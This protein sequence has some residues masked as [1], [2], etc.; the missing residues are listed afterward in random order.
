MEVI[1]H[2]KPKLGKVKMTC[3]DP[4][5][6]KLEQ[7][8]EAVKA[9]FSKPNFTMLCG[10]MGSG[11][12]STTIKCL[13][14]FLKKTHSDMIVVIP[15]VSLAS[16]NPADNVFSKWTPEGNLYHE[17]NEDTLKEIYE[18]VLANAE[19][20]NYTIVIIDDFGHLLK[21]KKIETMLQKFVIKIR[22]LKIGQLWL[23]TQNYF[24]T[25]KKLRELATNVF[26]WNSNKS[27]NEKFFT[28]QFQMDGEKFKQLLRHTPTIHNFFILNLKYKR[29]FN[30][31]WDEVVWKDAQ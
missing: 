9:C 30:D 25:P 3:D 31:N 28:E 5:D 18:K 16:I 4:I 21:D 26:L 15:E 6:P 17:L 29:I 10:G 7:N 12:T 1:H 11:K 14:G 8:G 19:E 24:Q 2:D 23:L 22:H 13:K 20:G 27:Q